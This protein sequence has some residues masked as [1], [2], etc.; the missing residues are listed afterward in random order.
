MFHVVA[1]MFR[2]ALHNAKMGNIVLSHIVSGSISSCVW[3]VVDRV[4]GRSATRTTI[5]SNGGKCIELTYFSHDCNCGYGLWTGWQNEEIEF[6]MRHLRLLQWHIDLCSLFI[7]GAWQWLHLFDSCSTRK[8]DYRFNGKAGE[9]SLVQ[10]FVW[11]PFIDL[12]QKVDETA[13]VSHY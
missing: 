11:H 7:A 4:L 5:W 6:R 1:T 13:I 9:S 3:I 2:W 12:P 8:F 10:A